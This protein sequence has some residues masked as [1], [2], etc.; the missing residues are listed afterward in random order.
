MC[1][2]RAAVIDSGGPKNG[3][4]LQITGSYV[5]VWGITISNAQK[6]VIVDGGDFVQIDNVE[7]HTIGDEAVHFRGTATDG[8][9]QDSLIHHTGLRRDKFGEGI[10]VGSAVSNWP[11]YSNGKPDQSDRVRISRNQIWDTTAESIDIKEGTS[12]GSVEFNSMDGTG[13]TGA[14]SWVDMKGN[15]Y[16][17]RGNVGVSAPE[18][19][20]QTHNIDN[21]GSGSNNEFISN[22]AQVDGP[23]YG[24]YI[25][26]PQSTDNIVSCTNLATKADSGFSNLPCSD[27]D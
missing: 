6:G 4:A 20:F 18:D 14:D 19:G 25:H 3:Y 17:I 8:V 1:G 22:T 15:G 11:K 5:G 10:Y 9:V 16:T 27:A 12:G 7:V 13:M 2:P 26:D 23:G 24:F 21:M